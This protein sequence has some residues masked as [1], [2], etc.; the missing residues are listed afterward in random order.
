MRKAWINADTGEVKAD[1]FLRRPKPKDPDGLSVAIAARRS[2]SQASRVLTNC[3][4]VVSVHVGRVRNLGLDVVPD[5]ED[6]A[7]ITGLPYPEDDRDTAEWLAGKLAK[8]A[9][10]QWTP[11]R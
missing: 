8:Q 3:G 7:N 4:G 6:H 10:L 2:P 11:E 5:S 9:R 1:A